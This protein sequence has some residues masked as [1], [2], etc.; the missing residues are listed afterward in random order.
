MEDTTRVINVEYA[1]LGQELELANRVH[2]EI[3]NDKIEHIGKGWVSKGEIYPN[4][5]LI[6]GFVNAH[7]HTFDG[8]IPEFGTNL[9]LKEAVGDPNSKKYELLINKSI[10]ELKRATRD[11]LKKSLEVGVMIVL[12]FK[13]LD[14]VGA[15]AAKG[16]FTEYPNNYI[17]LGRLDEEVT[18]ERLIKLRELVPGYG[19]SSVSS[20][21]PEELQLISKVFNDRIRAVHISE[22]LRQNLYNDLKLALSLFRANI[23]VHGTNLSND[24]IRTIADLGIPLVVCPR[25]NLWFSSGVPNIP[26][27]VKS[28]VNLLIGTDNASW[29]DHNLWKELEVALLISR[30]LSPGIDVARDLLKA[31]TINFKGIHPIE[32][33]RYITAGI[34]NVSSRFES[35]VNKY[36]ALI[37]EQGSLIKVLG[38]PRTLV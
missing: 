15:L 28:H 14:L 20:A 19:L 37:K 33:G 3:K 11:F 38:Q 35:A 8:L 18:E 1:L 29:I 22:N 34:F 13:E 21:S 26:E 12:D 16:I 27:M 4:S 10:D 31:S 23:L 25:S 6:P 36:S 32:E 17:P 7:V 5:I 2:L 9:S 24:E 30:W